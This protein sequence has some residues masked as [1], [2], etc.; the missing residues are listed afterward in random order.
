MRIPERPTSVS[1]LDLVKRLEDYAEGRQTW[2]ADGAALSASERKASRVL[3]TR[4]VLIVEQVFA[5]VLDRVT[6]KELDTFT[7][8]DRFHGLKVAHLMWHIL[9]PPRRSVLTA[10]EIGMLVLAAHLHDAG[11]ALS[12]AERDERLAPDSDLWDRAEASPTIKRNL[13]RLREIIT[14]PELPGP[15]RIRAESELFQ[16]EEALLALDTRERHATSDRYMELI[17]QIRGYHDKDRTRIPDIEECFSFDGDSFKEKLIDVC[18][19]HNQDADVLVEK[20]REHFDRYR[21]PR[22][23]PVGMGTVDTHLAAAALRLS[24]ILDFDR[25]RTPATL[26]HYLVPGT[27]SHSVN[28]SSLEWNKHL[29]IS[30]WEIDPTAVV[31]RGRCN[32]H[33]VHHSVVQFCGVIAEEIASTRATFTVTGAGTWP[34]VLPESV[35]AEIHEDG[36]HYVPYRFEL[37]DGRVYELLMG[38]AI[39]DNPL[40]AV[41]ELI[42]NA[43]DACTYRDALSKLAEPHITP[44]TQNRI[45][46]RYEEPVS[47]EE[48]PTLR[49]IDTGTGMDAWLIERWFLKVGRSYYNSTEFSRD[50]VQLR[51]QGL[52]FAP[53]SEFGIGFLSCFLLADRVDV[54]TGMWEPIR[55][56]TR[57]RH[58]EIDGPTRLIRIREDPNTGLRRLRGT[59]VSLALTRGGGMSAKNGGPPAWEDVKLYL[60]SI[61][62]DLPYRLNLE[63]ELRGTLVREFVDPKPVVAVLPEPYGSKALRIPVADP[64]GGLEG[65]IAI[66]PYPAV[67]VVDEDRLKASAVAIGQEN[68]VDPS[69]LLRGGFNV[70]RVPGLPSGIT[71]SPQVGATVKML[72]TDA[73][74]RRYARTNLAR[75]SPVEDFAIAMRVEAVWIKYLLDHRAEIPE[76]LLYGL[77]RRG[78]AGRAR[79]LSGH[80]WLETYSAL[81]LYELARNGWWYSRANREKTADPIAEWESGRGL[82]E[83]STEQFY[84]EILQLILPRIALERSMDWRGD[85]YVG[86]PTSDWREVLASW[87]DFI[88][89]PIPW[90]PFVQY[91]GK[92]SEQFWRGWSSKFLFN[93]K[94]APLLTE[95]T[96]RDLR[97]GGR[98]FDQLL[99]DRNE[100]RPSQL[101]E[102]AVVFL[103]RFINVVGDLEISSVYG[104]ATLNTFRRIK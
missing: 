68:E 75:T 30:N 64:T 25:E 84:E 7:M 98:I 4:I 61:C 31:F 49:V 89:S 82:A 12:R 53:V 46:V 32:N 27:L 1:E 39:Y 93:R 80:T 24:D 38:G 18:V 101:S 96:E 5:Y 37:D 36:Y 17:D 103:D 41:R 40:V 102:E 70:G 20:D 21:F 90:R 6:S 72:W 28:I 59:R 51:K 65:Q 54:E 34:F 92:I 44:D 73:E 69:V 13:D 74:G 78:L 55:G 95:F 45:T 99:R 23:Y 57:R 85:T 35:K 76:G 88:S 58:L 48:Y 60:Q 86:P 8:H 19:S 15:K 50:R 62:Q 97:S 77:Y 83:V 81:D 91:I 2:H 22:E 16:A 52:D 67:R 26:F 42:Q 29:S 94:Y 43:V 100:K 56:D 66:V 9:A 14:D 47:D 63:H 33:I 104:T 87:H 11:M 10:P 79:A 71:G 3:H